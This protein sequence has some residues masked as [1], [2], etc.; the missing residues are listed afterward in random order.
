[1]N[2][3]TCRSR[4]A[5]II[6]QI[7][8]PNAE[9]MTEKIYEILSNEGYNDGTISGALD[10]LKSQGYLNNKKNPNGG[11]S[12]LWYYNDKQSKKLSQV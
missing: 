11:Q 10:Y 2:N 5:E 9:F 6:L 8:K 7:A 4:V 1:M 3:Q 12:K